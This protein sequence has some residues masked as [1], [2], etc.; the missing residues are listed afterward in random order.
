MA[1]KK[2]KKSGVAPNG[3]YAID[4]SHTKYAAMIPYI[5][6]ELETE[7][8]PAIIYQIHPFEP[9]DDW[10]RTNEFLNSGGTFRYWLAPKQ[11][12]DAEEIDSS[13]R[14]DNVDEPA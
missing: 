11:F 13:S 4:Y 5:G 14:L 12:P 6:Q 3:K 9:Q 2:K 10:D 1:K 8:G 7:Q